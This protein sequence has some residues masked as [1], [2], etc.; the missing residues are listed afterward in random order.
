MKYLMFYDIAPDGLA[1]VQD[2][3]P[4]HQ[5]RLSE[6]HSRGDLLMAGPYGTPPVGAIGIFTTRIAAEEFVAGDPFVLNGVVGRFQIFEWLE[7]LT[8]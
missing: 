5:A 7:A 1:R 4:G 8:P 3:L 6:F 2:S